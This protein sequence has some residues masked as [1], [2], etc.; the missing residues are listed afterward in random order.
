MNDK[1]K[2]KFRKILLLALKMAIGGSVAYWIAETLYLQFASSAG[3]I[4]LLTLQTTKWETL[5][6]SVRRLLTFAFTCFICFVLFHIVKVSW[7]DYGLVLFILVFLSEFLGWRNTISINAVI[8]A[9]LLSARDF[10]LAF[11][12][13]ELMLVV[14][15]LTI[16]IVLNMFHINSEHEAGIIKAMR[17]VE[18]QMKSILQE[19]S[20]YLRNQSMEDYVWGNII[21]MED[22]LSEHLEMAHEFHNNTFGTHP[23]YYINYFTMRKQ[24]CGALQNLHAGMRRIRNLPVQAKIVA[25]YIDDMAF[26]VK[27]MNRPEKQIAQLKALLQKMSEQELPTTREE[28]ENR[29]LLYHMLMDLEEFLLF[30]VRFIES[31]DEQQF[32]IYWKTEILEK[33]RNLQK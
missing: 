8:A 30:K 25:D 11:L 9:H 31:I 7:I 18:H 24:Q 33:G 15:G 12:K 28:F 20:G 19:L 4:A 27:E 1:M 3:I 26:H 21:K 22:E 10:S 13:N 5:R 2:L 6:L 29:A 32:Q 14:I 23:E 16:A 17:R